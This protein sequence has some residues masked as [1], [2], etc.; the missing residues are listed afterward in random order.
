MKHLGTAF[1]FSILVTAAF[2]IA[3]GFLS[4]RALQ[5]VSALPAAAIPEIAPIPMER[6]LH[7]PRGAGVP[8]DQPYEAPVE[9]VFVSRPDGWAPER[10]PTSR[11]PVRVAIVI[12]GIG[13]DRTLD[14]RFAAI[15]YPLTF[16]VST[17]DQAPADSL[18][19]DPRAMLVEIEPPVTADKIASA[20][21]QWRAGGILTPVSGFAPKPAAI[22]RSLLAE[23]AFAIDGMAG[24]APSIYAAARAQRVSAATR[25][26]VIDAHEE[27]PYI[28]FMLRQTTKLARRT[29]VAIAVGHAYPETYEALRQNIP[30]MIAEGVEIVPAGTLVR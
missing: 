1:W 16:A 21:T 17:L 13:E 18:R 23:N 28:A 6:A 26:I 2:A 25:D 24:G 15:P 8:F 4:G 14:R 9:E 5:Q 19:A 11:E 29:G 10:R 30:K 27:E 22:V 3:S 20:L 12:C 7:G